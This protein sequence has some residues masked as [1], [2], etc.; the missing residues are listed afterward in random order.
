MSDILTKPKVVIAEKIKQEIAEQ[1]ELE[2][3]VV[4]HCQIQTPSNMP[5]GVRIWP[6]TFLLDNDSQ[7]QSKLLHHENIPLVPQWKEIP[8]NTSYTFTLFFSALPQSCAK[9]HMV[10]LITQSGGF[11]ALNLLRNKLDVYYVKI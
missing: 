8:P 10:E 11:E 4:V 2:A 5:M 7:H 1:E 3:Q 6:T 9:F